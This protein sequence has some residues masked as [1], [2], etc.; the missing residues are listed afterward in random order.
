[1]ITESQLASILPLNKNI[2]I[3]TNALNQI[4]PKYDITTTDRIASFI[5]QC[6]VESCE[7]TIFEENLKYS[8]KGLMSVWPNHFPTEDIAK[9]YQYKPE[10]ISNLVYAN[11]L[12][13]GSTESGDGWKYRGRGAI[14]LTGKSNWTKLSTYLNKSMDDTLS[15]GG[16]PSG[17]IESA[18]FFWYMNKLNTYADQKD[19]I[20]LTKHVNGPRCLGLEN[21]TKYWKKALQVLT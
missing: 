6:A 7:F 8:A 4:L 1:M 15:Y 18:C 9:Q 17:Q 11:F 5:G 10:M 13:N 20:T 14:Q 16:T 19:I 21:R 3:L 2:S 12:G